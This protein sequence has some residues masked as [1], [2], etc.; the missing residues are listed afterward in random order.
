MDNYRLTSPSQIGPL[1]TNLVAELIHRDTGYP[2]I[3]TTL[4]NW[5]PALRSSTFDIIY[6]PD[7]DRYEVVVSIN[8]FKT[9]KVFY[10]RRNPYRKHIATIAQDISI[11]LLLTYDL[12]GG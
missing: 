12:R 9:K 1:I 5:H 6:D 2:P 7:E 11:W 4:A 10:L 8:E 3:E